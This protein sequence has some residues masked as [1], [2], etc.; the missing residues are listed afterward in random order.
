MSD[1]KDFIHGLISHPIDTL[2]GNLDPPSA[3]QKPAYT[4]QDASGH[5]GSGLAKKGAE[6]ISSRAAHVDNAVQDASL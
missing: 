1:L 4:A 5:L 3:P 2:S 6:S